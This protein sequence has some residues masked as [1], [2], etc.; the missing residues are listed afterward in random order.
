MK[1][2]KYTAKFSTG[3][4]TRNSLHSYKTAGAWINT[5]TGKIANVTFSKNIATP[6]RVGVCELLKDSDRRWFASFA[7]FQEA[8]AKAEADAKLWKLEVVQVEV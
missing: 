4:V 5:E 8:K 6:S 2:T 3:T 1:D 7:K